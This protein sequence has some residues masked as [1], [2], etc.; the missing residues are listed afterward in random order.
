MGR[1]V[2]E[3][4]K[5]A[6]VQKLGIAD[7][8][9]ARVH[10]AQ[11]GDML[12]FT[13]LVEAH[14]SDVRR[15]VLRIVRDDDDA[16]DVAQETWIRVAANLGAIRDAERFQPWLRRIARN[17]SLDFVSRR[18]KDQ[19]S[20][21]ALDA[22]AD[23]DE[24]GPEGSLLSHDEQGRVWEAL[25]R[26]SEG[27]RFVLYLR[28]YKGLPYA[29]IAKCLG[30]TRNA[31]EVRVFRARE[32]FRAHYRSAELVQPGCNISVFELSALV[33][34]KMPDAIRQRVESH[35]PSCIDCRERLRAMGNGHRLLCQ[36]LPMF[37]PGDRVNIT[38]SDGTGMGNCEV[39]E[40]S[41]GLLRVKRNGAEVLYNL[42]STALLS[43][44][45]ILA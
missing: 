45:R 28:E 21:D 18:T 30:A 14:S 32:R 25:G 40:Y 36:E 7:L 42:R 3:F 17:C 38:F 4:G 24:A 44:N 5:V 20:D 12:A 27:D 39:I 8:D 23:A 37:D 13:E 33:E 10:R 6:L 2:G 34:G 1:L 22:I 11:A 9:E 19:H 35:V 15:V 43:I 16:N 41:N 31:A 29:E 26:L